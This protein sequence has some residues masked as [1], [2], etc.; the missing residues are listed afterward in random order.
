MNGEMVQ[1]QP[2][3]SD[4]KQKLADYRQEVSLNM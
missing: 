1:C 4:A 2:F 3:S